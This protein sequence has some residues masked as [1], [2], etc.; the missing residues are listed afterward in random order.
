M[1]VSFFVPS[2][3]EAAGGIG[4]VYAAGLARGLRADGVPATITA[5]GAVDF[6]A[7]PDDDLV[8]DGILLPPLCSRL[9]ELASRRTVAV[10]HHVASRTSNDRRSRAE[11]TESLRAMLP[12]LHRVIATSEQVAADLVTDFGVA[13]ERV[14]VV[15]PGADDL[16]RATPAPGGCQILST[17][18]LT[19]RK[20]HDFLLRALARLSDLDWTLT[21]AGEA[22]RDPA[23]AVELAALILVL[24]LDNRVSLITDA[25]AERLEP[26]WQTTSVFALTTRWEGYAAGVAQALRRGIPVMV[27]LEAGTLVSAGA[28][29]LC[30]DDDEATVSKVLRRLVF[31]GT[32]RNSMAEAAWNAGQA[33]PDWMTQA[34]RF[35]DVTGV[36]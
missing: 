30:P 34:R 7:V 33:Q 6:R 20:R 16:P 24:S 23:Y 15:C 14:F 25:S 19:R 12:R 18:V 27:T 10:M 4:T 36:R 22:T 5:G 32:L 35:A 9:E 3:S 8:I 1:A 31:D 13:P 11:V 17:G 28:G 26:I 21:I 2:R 29:V